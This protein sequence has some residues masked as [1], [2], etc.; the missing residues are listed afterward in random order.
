MTAKINLGRVSLVPA[1]TW[2][3][4]KAYKRLDTVTYGMGAYVAKADVPAGTKTTDEAYWQRIVDTTELENNVNDAVDG[5]N[6]AE[7]ARAKAEQGRVAAETARVTAEDSRSKAEASRVSV[8][9]ERVTA[10]RARADAETKRAEAEDSRQAKETERQAAEASRVAEE[11]ARDEAEDAR[12][13]AEVE[14][15]NNELNRKTSESEREK[16]ESARAEAEGKRA[17]A[18]TARAAAESSRSEAEEERVTAEQVRATAE[19]ARSEAETLRASAESARAEAEEQRVASQASNDERQAK[20]DADQ[21]A[22]NA[23][24]SGITFVI[25]EAGQ[26]DAGTLMPTVTGENGK[27][28]LVPDPKGGEDNL[29]LE[30]VWLG[31]QRWEHIGSA[32]SSFDAI[33]T[34][35]VD[36]VFAGGNPSG[37]AGLSLT[38]LS[39]TWVKLNATYAAKSHTHTKDE[40]TDLADWAKADEK[41]SYKPEEVGLEFATESEAV[42]YLREA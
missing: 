21:R 28:Y 7:S 35:Q 19:S 27:M 23:A 18:E 12:S 37:T 2:D 38:G 13:V 34:D 10:E 26:Y 14:R 24:A 1:G 30:W 15:G 40:I 5:V 11:T 6:Q 8:E 17:A 20:N 39:Y 16:E 36:A 9:A 33:T 22:N 42:D 3:G 32:S 41:P 31:G 29:Y 4:T 25:L